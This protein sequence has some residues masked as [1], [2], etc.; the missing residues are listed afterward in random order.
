MAP[1]KSPKKSKATTPLDWDLT[2][3]L[4]PRPG[5]PPTDRIVRRQRWMR[6]Y[7]ATSAVTLPLV[8]FISFV[9]VAN[10]KG[11]GT[12]S[13]GIAS[14][15]SSPGRTAATLEMDQWLGQHPSPLP[16]ASVL[17]WDGA[18]QYPAPAGAPSSDWPMELDHFTLRVGRGANPRLYLATVEVVIQSNG[19]TALGGPSISPDV[20]TAATGATLSNGPWPGIVAQNQVTNP[21]QGAINGWLSAYTS[22]SASQLRL[23]VGDSTTDGAYV[24]LSGVTS[25]TDSV[26]YD[27]P[28]AA[29]NSPASSGTASAAIVEVNLSLQWRGESAPASG[30]PPTT[31][32]LLVERA[33]TSAPVVVAWGPAGTGP[34][35]TPYQNAGGQH[36]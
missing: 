21:V 2:D 9:A 15:T 19:A 6:R 10:S 28:R 20:A 16:G 8:L 24:P 13:A 36:G 11:T 1:K 26:T 14:A 34:Y 31:L 17:E 5:L 33:N 3:D 7:V 22:G 32:D 23:A 12:T 25:A 29:P 4:I 30:G 18:T 35:L 27:A